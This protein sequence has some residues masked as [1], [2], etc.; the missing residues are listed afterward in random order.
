MAIPV[1]SVFSSKDSWGRLVSCRMKP[2]LAL[3]LSRYAKKVAEEFELVQAKRNEIIV[4]NGEKGEG[5][6][7]SVKP[8]SPGWDAFL[9]DMTELMGSPTELEPFH[10]SIDE[11]AEEIGKSEDNALSVADCGALEPFFAV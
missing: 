10:L 5:G 9:Q 2:G 4:A 1:S 11:L 8:T 6:Q 7:V 3:K